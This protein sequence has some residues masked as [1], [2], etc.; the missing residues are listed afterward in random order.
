MRWW[1]IAIVS[2]M[3]AGAVQAQELS[4]Q[5]VQVFGGRDSMRVVDVDPIQIHQLDTLLIRWTPNVEPDLAGYRIIYANGTDLARVDI[6]M[7]AEVIGGK[8]QKRTN[9]ILDV[10]GCIWR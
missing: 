10:G 6:G 3:F 2:L 8:I 1:T 7:A 4:W 5:W 9:V